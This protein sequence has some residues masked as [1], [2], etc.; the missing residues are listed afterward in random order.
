[1]GRQSSGPQKV[2]VRLEYSPPYVLIGIRY[3]TQCFYL[4]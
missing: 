3:F 1:M 4:V 2:V